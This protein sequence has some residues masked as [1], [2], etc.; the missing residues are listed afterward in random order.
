MEQADGD[1]EIA[2]QDQAAQ[3]Q[4]AE[5]LPE[6]YKVIVD[7]FSDNNMFESNSEAVKEEI[8]RLAI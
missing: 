6:V 1:M 5:S 2:E 4:E 7:V 8:E 3:K